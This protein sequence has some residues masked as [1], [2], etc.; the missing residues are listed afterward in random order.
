MVKSRVVEYNGRVTV[1]HLSSHG[2]IQNN[3]AML[4]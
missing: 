3:Q 1:F 4:K 2:L